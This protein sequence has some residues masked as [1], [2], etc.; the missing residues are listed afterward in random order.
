M[1]EEFNVGFWLAQ[2]AVSAPIVVML[3]VGM[4]VCYRQRKRRPHVAKLIG[5]A[6]FAELVWIVVGTP[7]MFLAFSGLE[8]ANFFE[9]GEGEISWMM[10]TILSNLPGSTVNAAIWGTVLWAVL[11][12]DDLREKSVSH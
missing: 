5:W 4:V 3:V 12:V 1:V 10:R 7:L 6:L 9:A 2:A 11:Q 8:G